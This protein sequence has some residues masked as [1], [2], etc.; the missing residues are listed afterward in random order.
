MMNRAR[1]IVQHMLE[2]DLDPEEIDAEQA[3][4]RPPP[5]VYKVRS[6]HGG[7]KVDWNGNVINLELFMPEEA[8]ETEDLKHI[9]R[10]DLDEWRRYHE[11]LKD[12]PWD[13]IDILDLGYWLDDG[14]YEEPE[15]DWR[16]EMREQ[17]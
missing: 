11:S 10:F 16:R 5:P 12:D 4:T 7:F 13:S 15:W 9:V 1:Q 8:K 17:G 6:S 14:S 3:S 2:S